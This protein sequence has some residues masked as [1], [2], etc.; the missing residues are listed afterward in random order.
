MVGDIEC[1]AQRRKEFV[2]DVVK[3]S[4]HPT[5]LRITLHKSRRRWPVPLLTR[6]QP[7]L[8]TARTIALSAVHQ[9]T[10]DLVTVST[11]PLHNPSRHNLSA[12][13]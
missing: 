3:D 4:R 7:L 2:C 8:G 9:A 5:D 11:N 1:V 12:S 13:F 10:L 6:T